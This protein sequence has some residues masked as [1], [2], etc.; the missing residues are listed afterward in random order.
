MFKVVDIRCLPTPIFRRELTELTVGDLHANPMLM[1]YILYLYGA[2][3]VS[4]DH[5]DKMFELYDMLTTNTLYQE[6]SRIEQFKEKQGAILN[7][8]E[9]FESIDNQQVQMA[10][11]ARITEAVRVF[12]ELIRKISFNETSIVF[13]FLG[14]ELADRGACDLFILELLDCMM[15]HNIPYKIILSNHG[16]CFLESFTALTIQGASITDNDR[17]ISQQY[18]GSFWNFKLLWDWK[19]FNLD[20]I[21]RLI[22]K[23]YLPFISLV[24]MSFDSDTQTINIYSHAAIGL[25]DLKQIATDFNCAWSDENL[26][27]IADS[28][29]G[30][31]MAFK[32]KLDHFLKVFA[33]SASMKEDIHPELKQ[34]PETCFWKFCWNRQYGIDVIFRPHIYHNYQINYFYGH[35]SSNELS[36]KPHCFCLDGVLGKAVQYSSIKACGLITRAPLKVLP[37]SGLTYYQFKPREVVIRLQLP[38]N[39][40]LSCFGLFALGMYFKPSSENEMPV[41]VLNMFVQKIMGYITAP[42]P[43]FTKEF[44]RRR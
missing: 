33:Q 36:E 30:I 11:K 27:Q 37:K 44:S 32:T 4:Q 6:L 39:T 20:D 2:I 41:S 9:Q 21:R 24:D 23:V 34:L 5:Y 14:D 16:L 7:W 25:Y 29:H 1:I 19:Q 12:L 40:I 3:N 31:Q 17:M 28:V 10:F 26:V 42:V 43:E 18:T 15:Q 35:D 38:W 22:K 13:R 8:S